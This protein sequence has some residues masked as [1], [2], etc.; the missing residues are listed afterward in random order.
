MK[1]IF[2][3]C[4]FAFMLLSFNADAKYNVAEPCTIRIRINYIITG[5]VGKPADDCENFGLNCLK[6]E[7]G[8]RVAS[9]NLTG[10]APGTSRVIFEM[11]SETQLSITFLGDGTET[12]AMNVD[13]EYN[14]DPKIAADLGY[15]SITIMRG[16][17]PVIKNRDG[18]YTSVLKVQLK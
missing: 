16:D 8:D 14:L 15:S 5:E 9:L 12:G 6:I 17:Y 10:A 7:K 1:S 11:N 13:K 4:L 2:S 3:V 18:S